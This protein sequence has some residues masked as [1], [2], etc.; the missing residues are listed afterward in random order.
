MN[1]ETD[2][3]SA[4]SS[5]LTTIISAGVLWVAY[6]QI[7]QV[8]KQLKGLS[9]NQKN[10]TLMT[11]LELESELNKR[12]ENFDKSNFELREYNLEIETSNKEL[13]KDLLDIYADKIEVSMENYL[14]SLDRLSY[15]ILH[16]YLSDRD[17]RTEYRDTIFDA[18]DNYN[19]KFGVSTRYRNTVKIYEKW[20][21]E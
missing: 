17:W 12:K 18:V 7:K 4:I 15:C 8:K 16:N 3:I 2:W 9:D 1:I 14:N 6:Y 13:N 21:S 10:S 20:K 5:A 11:V 19:E